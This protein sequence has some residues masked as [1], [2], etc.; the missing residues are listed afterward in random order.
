M[1]R[2]P[3]QQKSNYAV[4]K[5][6]VFAEQKTKFSIKDFFSKCTFTEGILNGKLHFLCSV[7]CMYY[8]HLK[9]TLMQI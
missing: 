4:C 8:A 9:G 3:A 1:S 2:D 6:A 5:N 7:S